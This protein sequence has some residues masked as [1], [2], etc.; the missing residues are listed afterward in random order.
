MC[1]EPGHPGIEG[2]FITMGGYKTLP[3]NLL[4]D[5]MG[6]EFRKGMVE[7]GRS[8]CYDSWEDWKSGGSLVT[9]VSGN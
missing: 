5:A 8:L 1:R 7:Y 4:T 6:W 2:D 9:R 3:F